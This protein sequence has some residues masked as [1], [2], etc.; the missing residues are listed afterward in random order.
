MNAPKFTTLDINQI[1][2]DSQNPRIKQFLENYVG[3]PTSEQISL[4][5]SDSGTGDATTSYRTLRESIR[6]SKGIIHPIVVNH[7]AEGEMVVIEGNTRLQIYKEFNESNPDGTWAMI[8]SLLYEQMS[9]YDIHS[10]RLQSHLVGPRDWDPY[11][12]AK[13]LFQLSEVEYLPMSQIISLCGGKSN[14]I[15]KSIDAYK[16]M[17]GAYRKYV[18]DNEL[19][20]EPREFSKFME[21]QNPRIKNAVANAGYTID[22]FA[23]WVAEGNIDKAQGVRNLPDILKSDK[24]KAGSTQARASQVRL[25]MAEVEGIIAKYKDIPVFVVGDM[26]CEE[27]TVPMQQFIQA[28]YVPCY[29]AATVYGD[30][31]NGHHICSPADGYSTASRRKADTREGGAIDHLFIYDPAGTAEVKV[32]DCIMEE[33]TVKL[34]DHYPNIIDVRL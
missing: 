21:Y 11:S 1:K 5:L 34:T 33:Y 19:D 12:K 26:N 7:T 18:E 13:Y 3:E 25:I 24:A 15:T 30:N 4:A 6:V 29:K 28:G 9:E 20:F 32:F 16:C 22:T 14:E 23:E 10:I 2:L 31:H 8:P 27:N 17:E